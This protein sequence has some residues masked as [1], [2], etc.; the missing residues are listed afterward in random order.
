MQTIAI[1][2]PEHDLCLANGDANYVPPA[3]ALSFARKGAGIMNTLYGDHVV[4]VAAEDVAAVL[5]AD[6][7]LVAWGWNATLVRQLCRHGVPRSLM[8]SDERLEAIR[9]LSHRRAAL[10][11]ACFVAEACY[12]AAP[13]VA[14]VCSVGKVE[15]CL[16]DHCRVVLKA[17]WSGSGRGL[18]WVDGTLSET[19]RHWIS[20]IISRQGSVMVEQRRDVVIDFALEYYI[21]NTNNHDVLR[22]MQGNRSL[23]DECPQVTFLGYSLFE[24]QS[25]V[26]RGNRL[27]SDQAIV[28]CLSAYIPRQA[29][30]Q[31]KEA[32]ELWLKGNVSPVYSGPLGVDMFVYR[33][34]DG[35]A[36]NPVVE[37]NVR[38]TMGHVSIA[39]RGETGNAL[40]MPDVQ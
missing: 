4:A 13:T 26:Y 19:D 8:P 37:I 17:P 25:G 34:A 23:Q 6:C 20:R 1:F 29:I 31:A 15:A 30:W 32:V 28:D 21:G 11:A 2:N 9:A 39:M 33:T 38:H 27:L 24:T 10:A 3:S 5:C 35:Y 18:R 7:S 36:L 12:T 16:D 14:E 22:T 40:F